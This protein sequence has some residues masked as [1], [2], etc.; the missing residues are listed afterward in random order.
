MWLFWQQ[1]WK[2][3]TGFRQPRPNSGKMWSFRVSQAKWKSAPARLLELIR[4]HLQQM[5]LPNLNGYLL[6]FFHMRAGWFVTEVKFKLNVRGIHD[7]HKMLMLSWVETKGMIKW[8]LKIHDGDEY[9]ITAIPCCY[10]WFSV[11]S[12]TCAFK[13]PQVILSHVSASQEGA[14]QN[15]S[16]ENNYN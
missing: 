2:A 13:W 5:E 1:R 9:E 10:G 3:H 15:F 4:T 16:H 7:C 11:I 6:F 8:W 12:E 14:I